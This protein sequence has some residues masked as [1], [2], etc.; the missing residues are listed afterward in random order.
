[1]GSQPGVQCAGLA[2]WPIFRGT[3]WS[4]QVLIPGQA[5]SDREEIFY[6]I[7]PQYFA[8][9]RTP[10]IAGRDFTSADAE[11][12]QPTPAIINE[13]FAR[14]YFNS[15][16]V[17]GREF[18]YP[19]RNAPARVVIVGV[20]ADAQYYNLR[21]QGEPMVYLPVEGNNSFT[22]YVRSQLPL[23]QTVRLVE[24][25][26][27]ALG[28][29]TRVREVTSLATIVGNTL[30]RERLLAGVGGTCALFGLLLAAIG[31]FGLLSYTVG[32][33]TREI[34][35]RVAL[36]A[37]RRQIVSLVLR[38]VAGLI[39]FGLATGLGGAF[40]V[41]AAFRSLLFGIRSADAFVTGTAVALFL[42]TGMLAAGLPA[43]RAASV[44]P[45]RALREE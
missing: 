29:G 14:R 37:Q 5:P 39:G 17:V 11:T 23:G 26:T 25:E 18:S 3:G 12:R 20:A 36:G 35:V 32:R 44:D 30:V 38:D 41:L 33:R 13:A 28:S 1:V 9:L 27:H 22:L 8:T 24:R 21:G 7:S 10:L 19:F 15:R 4:S 16:N 6:R 40:A 42:L 2:W 34:G 45:T 43:H 31:L